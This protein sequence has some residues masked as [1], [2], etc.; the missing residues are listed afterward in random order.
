MKF[1]PRIHSAESV[2]REI[3]AGLESGTIAL[4]EETEI[5]RAV[6][7]AVS[8]LAQEGYLVAGADTAAATAVALRALRQPVSVAD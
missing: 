7:V 1:F 2:A 3:V 6:R 8:L 4:D 5:E